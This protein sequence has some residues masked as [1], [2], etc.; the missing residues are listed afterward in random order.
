MKNLSISEQVLS[1]DA[2]T[3]P[4]NLIKLTNSHGLSVTLSD[5]GASI[6]AASFD[7]STQKIDFVLNYQNLSDWANNPYYFGVTAG[8]VA[9]RIAKA[10]YQHQGKD[11]KL[12]ANEGQNQ[13]HGGPG[14][15]STRTWAY[16]T[17]L[18]DQDAAVTFRLTSADKDQGFPGNLDIELEYRLTNNN[19]LILSYKAIADQSTPVCLTNHAYWNIAGTH[20]DDVL[21]Q[22]LQLPASNVLALDQEQIPTG[23]LMPT[24]GSAF[25]FSQGKAIGE[26]IQQL[27][28]GYDHYFVIDRDNDKS[29]Q[30]MASLTDPKSGRSMEIYSTELGVQFYSSNFLDGSLPGINGK[31]LNKHAAL[32]LETHGYPDAV[33]HGHF[34]NIIV[35]KG[36]E[37]RQTTIHRFLN[38]PSSS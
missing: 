11:Y 8:R 24:A 3:A 34:P 2:L 29:L 23:E 32:C 12:T 13:L 37:Y 4:V 30:K 36:E 6:W 27:E 38:L 28:N 19:E 31:P 26:D 33:N 9:N 22:T 18:S 7:N 20:V 16:E 5:L 35:N 17:Q 15:I 1:D 25:D 14:G 10:S 21:E